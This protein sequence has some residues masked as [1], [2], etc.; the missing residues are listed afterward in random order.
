M[1]GMNV[2]RKCW[3]EV[4]YRTAFGIHRARLDSDTKGIV[5]TQ[6]KCAL[7]IQNSSCLFE[8]RNER[9]VLYKTKDFFTGGH[10]I[11]F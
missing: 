5:K 1:R 11:P 4:L 9:R 10:S 3:Y 2:R 8:Y 6:E 7:M